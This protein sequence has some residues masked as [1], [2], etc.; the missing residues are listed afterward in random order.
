M[1]TDTVTIFNRIRGDRGEPDT[2]LPTVIK[3]VNLNI[4]RAAILAKYGAECQDKAILN[5][6]YNPDGMMVA[7]KRWQEPMAWNH[8]DDTLTFAPAKDFFWAGE[9]DGGAVSDDGFGTDGFYGH[10]NRTKDNVFL[11][12]S[13]ARYS[14]IPHFEVMGR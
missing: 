7:D 9:W 12:S 5:I 2:W 4:D 8:S 1:Y 11:I 10:M 13:V 3:G 6:R 14:V